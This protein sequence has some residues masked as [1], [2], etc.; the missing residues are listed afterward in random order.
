MDY[1]G[2]GPPVHGINTTKMTKVK[3]ELFSPHLPF[4]KAWPANKL[5]NLTGHINK[6]NGL[7][8]SPQD[9]QYQKTVWEEAQKVL[10][11]LRN[12]KATHIHN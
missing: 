2:Y 9:L 5:R 3:D 8:A 6:F 11:C 7:P 12:S 10:K 4:F 1:N